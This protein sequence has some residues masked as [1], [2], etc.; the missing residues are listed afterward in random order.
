MV[1][2]AFVA[3][4]ALATRASQPLPACKSSENTDS[5]EKYYTKVGVP[6]APH[7]C[8]A[9]TNDTKCAFAAFDAQQGTCYLK[10]AATL[11]PRPMPGVTLFT[12][13]QRPHGHPHSPPPP[14]VPT[15]PLPA[16]KYKVVLA[17]H[18]PLPAVSSANPPGKGASPCPTTFNPSYVEV[19]GE[20]K[21][22]G[23][24]VRTDNCNATN[25]AMSWAPCDVKTGVC[26]DLNASYQYPKSQGTEDPRIIFN[27]HD[28]YFY[29]FAYGTN[30]AQAHAD[31]CSTSGAPGAPGACTVVLSRTKTPV[32]PASWQHVPGGTY[33]WHRNGC[34][35]MQPAGQRSYCARPSPSPA[36]PLA[37]LSP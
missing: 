27:P 20:N 19:A 30:S 32:E 3:L 37:P 9:C 24:I 1:S 5:V 17:E 16:P 8:A 15:P 10:D 36:S 22:G 7:C 33:P 35:W 21:V 26:G 18:S 14:P 28:E 12:V 31:G 11:T 4:T 25:G 29:N 2:V 6:S 34:C 23:V 13:H